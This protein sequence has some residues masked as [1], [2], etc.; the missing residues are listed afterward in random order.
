MGTGRCLAQR[1]DPGV[2]AMPKVYV[3]ENVFE[4]GHQIHKAGTVQDCGDATA[5]FL[6]DRGWARDLTAEEKKALEEGSAEKPVEDGKKKS[7]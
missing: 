4:N 1:P 3:Q 5:K 2:N 6:K 7:K